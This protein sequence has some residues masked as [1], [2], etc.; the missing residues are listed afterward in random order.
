MSSS[1]LAFDDTHLAT[2]TRPTGPVAAPLFALCE[3]HPTTGEE[4]LNALALGIEI[5]CRMS[6][7]LLLPPANPIWDFLSPG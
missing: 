1:A 3:K 5:E 2:V 7:V 6:N 4:F